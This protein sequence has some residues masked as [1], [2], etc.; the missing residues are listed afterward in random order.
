MHQLL[1]SLKALL[2]LGVLISSAAN[3]NPSI[4]V[5]AFELNDMTDLPNAPE[6]LQR[7]ALLSTTF[8]ESLKNQG[9][10]VIPVDTKVQ[11]EIE[12]HSP[13]Y[14]YD[15][16]G[17]AIELNKEMGA[18]YLV[19]GV[20]LKPTYLFVYPRLIIVDINTQTV[21]MSNSAQLESSWTDERTTI[22]TAEK[23]A[24]VVKQRLDALH[25]KN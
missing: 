15:N 14:L 18:D 8:K 17:T 4:I 12:K 6:E 5:L 13:T 7:I 25:A 10:N 23:L 24:Q 19:I 3:A 9:V 2:L 22:R 11:A 16:V 1:Q 21:V 20:A